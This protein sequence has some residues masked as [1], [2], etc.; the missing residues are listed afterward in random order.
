[1]STAGAMDDRPRWARIAH[2]GVLV[3]L[4]LAVGLSSWNCLAHGDAAWDWWYPA[5][6][7]AALVGMWRRVA[8]GRGLFSVFSVMLALA[9]AGILIPADDDDHYGVVA[10]KRLFGHMPPL[11]ICWLIVVGVAALVLAP[12]VLV[13][14]RRH[15]FRSAAW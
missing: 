14:W 7:A 11:A 3:E 1:M 13:G 6:C 2:A 4:L 9:L 10:F 8:W 5:L 15:W 12:A